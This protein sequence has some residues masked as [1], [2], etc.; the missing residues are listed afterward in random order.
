MENIEKYQ[1]IRYTGEA[2][3]PVRWDGRGTVAAGAGEAWRGRSRGGRGRGTRALVGQGRAGRRRSRHGQGRSRR[4]AGRGARC[5]ARVVPARAGEA[6]PGPGH[7]RD[8]SRRAPAASEHAGEKGRRLRLKIEANSEKG[9]NAREKEW[10]H[11][12]DGIS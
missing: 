4:G 3:A 12:F 11:M 2:R 6:R 8:G 1:K 7:W 10:L 5:A 9:K